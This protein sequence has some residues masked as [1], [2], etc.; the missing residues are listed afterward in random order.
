MKLVTAGPS[1]VEP[2]LRVIEPDLSSIIDITSLGRVACALA[3]IVNV[4]KPGSMRMKKVLMVAVAL[5][6]TT[7]LLLA[8]VVTLIMTTGAEVSRFIPLP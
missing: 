8:S 5:T 3:L 1:A 2:P 6:F 7:E 4:P